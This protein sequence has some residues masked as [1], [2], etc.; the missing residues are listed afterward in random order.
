MIYINICMYD[1]YIFVYSPGLPLQTKK[2]PDHTVSPTEDWMT[3]LQIL[4]DLW[5]KW[6]TP[7][8]DC[9]H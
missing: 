8:F 2:L 5:T 6:R 3:E 4:L 9:V 1:V 7:E